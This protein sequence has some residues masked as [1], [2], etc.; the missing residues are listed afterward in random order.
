PDV[1]SVRSVLAAVAHAQVAHHAERRPVRA[2]DC[3]RATRFLS[4][5]RHTTTTFHRITAFVDSSCTTFRR[6]TTT[7]AGGRIRTGPAQPVSARPSAA[8]IEAAP[9]P[10]AMEAA[11]LAKAR[12]RAPGRS[13]A[14]VSYTKG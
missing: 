1:S 10:A 7:G 12:N 2:A 11:A 3:R 14:N 8:P 9:S 6:M 5:Y 4:D 13:S